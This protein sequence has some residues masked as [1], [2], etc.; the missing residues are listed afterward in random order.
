MIV[1]VVCNRDVDSLSV[2]NNMQFIQL[3]MLSLL[4]I[5]T[6]VCMPLNVV[7]ALS[8]LSSTFIMIIE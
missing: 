7:S 2:E 1:L 4:E 6:G 5:R 8:G 3:C